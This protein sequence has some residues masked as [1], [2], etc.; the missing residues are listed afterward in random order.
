MSGFDEIEE[1]KVVGSFAFSSSRSFVLL[2]LLENFFLLFCDVLL[3]LVF[4]IKMYVSLF[5]RFLFDVIVDVFR[6]ESSFSS[7]RRRVAR[8]ISR[9]DYFEFDFVCKMC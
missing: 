7:I 2:L 5:V 1:R 6:I 8:S 9:V 3:V 4:I